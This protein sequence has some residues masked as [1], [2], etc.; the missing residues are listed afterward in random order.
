MELWRALPL[1]FNTRAKRA[2]EILGRFDDRLGVLPPDNSLLRRCRL[3][4]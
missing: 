2:L 4:N 1:I 3:W